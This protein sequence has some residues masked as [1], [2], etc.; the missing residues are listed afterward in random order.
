MQCRRIGLTV[1][2]ILLLATGAIGQAGRKPRPGEAAKKTA[3]SSPA[4]QSPAITS[5]QQEQ[6]IVRLGTTLVT[7]PVIASDRSGIYIPDMRKDELSLSEDG[8]K[9]DIVFFATVDEPFQVIL[10]L[11]TSASTQDKLAQIQRAAIAFVEELKP[12]DRVK[13]IAFDDD[14]RDLNDFTSDRAALRIAIRRTKPGKGTRLYDAVRLAIQNL[15][16]EKGRKAL[17]L[18]TDGVDWH[19]NSAT[20]E[21]NLRT[22]EESE[23]IV[24]PIRYETRAETEALA[25]EQERRGR[26]VDP[27]IIFGDPRTSTPPTIPGGNPV[28]DGRTGRTGPYELP[29]PPV[30]IQPPRRD[31]YPGGGRYPDDR[32]GGGRYPDPRTPDGGRYPDDRSGGGR[33]PDP[34]TPDG[35]RYPDDRYPTGRNDPTPRTRGTRDDSIGVLMDNLYEV[36]DRY[37]NDLATTSGG[38]LCRA[39]TLISL[40]DV[41]A[42][43]AAE[44]RTQYTLGYYPSNTSRDGTYRRIQVRSNRKDVV[45]NARPG[46]RTVADRK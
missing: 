23:I 13:V 6:E 46:Y 17:V 35:G 11:D 43:I 28:P 12:D 19:S 33:Y 2:L 34:R 31:P 24:Y 44:L 37:L 36:A 27:S 18:F 10:M 14:I 7:V 39:D 29:L 45:I 3:A 30:V 40:P 5:D 8:V 42:R 21:D 26:T 16:Y 22:L 38:R 25:R 41:F 20:Y 1:P 15:E 9:Q 32:S 4:R